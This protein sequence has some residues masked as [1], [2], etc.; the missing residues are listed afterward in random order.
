MKMRLSFWS[1]ILGVVMFALPAAAFPA[2]TA[3]VND[4]AGVLQPYEVERI[5][6]RI[7]DHQTRTTNQIALLVVRNLEGLPIEDYTLRVAREWGGGQR[8]HDNGILVVFALDDHRSR[9]EVGPGLQ[10]AV[11]DSVTVAI[12]H[13][14]RPQLRASAYGDAFYTTVDTLVL[15]TGGVPGT[16][17]P[18]AR[19]T[20]PADSGLSDGAIFLIILGAFLLIVLVVYLIRR[21]DRSSSGY[22]GGGYSSGYGGGGGYS[23]NSTFVYL[24]G[25][26]GGSSGGGSSGGGSSG[27]GSSDWG[28]SSS[29]NDSSSGGGGSFD[30]GGGSSDW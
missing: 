20:A 17:R 4:Y 1:L 6:A 27:G 12:L 30:G 25:G 8:G 22:Y 11:P 2:I 7:R 13:S 21:S 14:I 18:A 15:R 29:S 28:S 9:I 3:P 24:G 10:A 5:A 16:Y 23:S 26:G 19:V